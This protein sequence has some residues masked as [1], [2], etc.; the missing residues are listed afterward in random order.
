M[1]VVLTGL[2][3][4][5]I[6]KLTFGEYGPND[7][8][9]VCTGTWETWYEKD[10]ITSALDIATDIDVNTTKKAP[11]SRYSSIEVFWAII[12]QYLTHCNLCPA[13]QK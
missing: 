3:G 6:W 1:T 8:V 11:V 7:F 9:R 5:V 4:I 10:I 13:S 12:S 2:H